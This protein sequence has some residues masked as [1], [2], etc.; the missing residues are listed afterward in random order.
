L[1]SSWETENRPF[2]HYDKQCIV[3]P[4]KENGLMKK[5]QWGKLGDTVHIPRAEWKPRWHPDGLIRTSLDLT[6]DEYFKRP[7]PRYI[8]EIKKKYRTELRL[9]KK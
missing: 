9:H 6:D 5:H 1:P 4:A 2:S 8:R 3:Q 7:M